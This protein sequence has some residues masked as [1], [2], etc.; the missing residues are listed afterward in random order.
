[1]TNHTTKHQRLAALRPLSPESVSSLATAWD[2]RMVDESNSIEGNS[3]T[4]RE[5]ELVLS[6]SVTVSGKPLKDHLEAVK[7]P[8]ER[9][10]SERWVRRTSCPA[11]LRGCETSPALSFRPTGCRPDSV[12]RI[13]TLLTSP[14]TFHSASA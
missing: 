1:M 12:D 2:V 14:N 11:L 10:H 9:V 7:L 5:T 4:L 13:S 3:L 6:K 8:W